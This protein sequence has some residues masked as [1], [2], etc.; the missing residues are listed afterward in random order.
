MAARPPLVTGGWMCVERGLDPRCVRRALEAAWRGCACWFPRGEAGAVLGWG[1]ELGF[2]LVV[3]L[4][5]ACCLVP[6]D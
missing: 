6:L 4:G 5:G 3:F 2:R 1:Q